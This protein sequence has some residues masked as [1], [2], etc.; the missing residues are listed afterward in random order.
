[1]KIKLFWCWFQNFHKFLNFNEIS[2]NRKICWNEF[3]WISSPRWVD[4]TCKLQ[5]FTFSTVH[6]SSKF[7]KY[8]IIFELLKIKFI[9]HK[10]LILSAFSVIFEISQKKA[11]IEAMTCEAKS[12]KQHKVT[13]EI[14]FKLKFS[15][16]RSKYFGFKSFDFFSEISNDFGSNY[17]YFCVY[18]M[19]FRFHKFK[20]WNLWN[21]KCQCEL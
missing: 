15:T 8:W 9:Q 1:M 10:I 4:S 5:I 19:I 6:F 12:R 16:L 7:D 11:G 14:E 13:L 20:M 3:H 2:W 21:Y 18:F 17:R